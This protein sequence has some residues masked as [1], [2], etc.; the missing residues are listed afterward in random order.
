MKGIRVEGLGFMVSGLRLRL[1]F[2]CA[3]LRLG[4]MVEGLKS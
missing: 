4:L 2:S 3:G 1:E